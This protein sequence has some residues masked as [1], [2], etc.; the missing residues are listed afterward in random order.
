M[1]GMNT[2]PAGATWHDPHDPERELPHGIQAVVRLPDGKAYRELVL[3]VADFVPLEAH[4][5][6]PHDGGHTGGDHSDGGHGTS[7][8]INPPPVPGSMDEH[9]VTAVNYRCE[10][11]SL[12]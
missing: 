5:P 1:G 11:L 2:E 7:G 12:R 4:L 10:P 8:P 9:G 3:A 6:G